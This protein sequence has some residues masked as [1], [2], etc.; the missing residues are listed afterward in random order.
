MDINNLKNSEKIQGDINNYILKEDIG[1]GSFGKLKLGIYKPTGEE[2][3]IKVMNKEL[4]KKKM[5]NV[6]F[7]ENEIVTRFHHINVINV[8]ELIED[9]KNFYIIMEYCKNGELFEYIIKKR[10]LSEIESSMFFYQLINGVSYIHQKGIAHR[11]LKPENLLLTKDN[12]LKIIDFGLSHEF[13]GNDLLKTKCGSPSYAAPEL[14]TGKNYDGFKIDIWCC[15][16][17]LFSMVTGQLPFYGKNKSE[18]FQSILKCEP[19]YPDY[20]SKICKDLI[21][22]ILVNDPKKR[23]TIEE[24]KKSDFY[25]QG[26]ELC[27]ANYNIDL[28]ELDKKSYCFK[29]EE[30]DKEKETITHISDDIESH[31]DYLNKINTENNDENREDMESQEISSN[32]K[33]KDFFNANINNNY[34]KEDIIYKN[35]NIINDTSNIKENQNNKK[36]KND[37]IIKEKNNN[38]KNIEKERKKCQILLGTIKE[39]KTI[40]K[41]LN[42]NSKNINNS[43]NSFRKKI[44]KINKN[45]NNIT[46]IKNIINDDNYIHLNKL[47]TES[48]N[49]K[50]SVLNNRFKL[51]TNSNK[52]NNISRYNIYFNKDDKDFRLLETNVND[53][54]KPINNNNQNFNSLNPNQNIKLN[55]KIIIDNT[56]LN[57]PKNIYIKKEK[58]NNLTT[59]NTLNNFNFKNI[60][61]KSFQRNIQNSTIKNVGNILINNNLYSNDNNLNTII[62]N[63]NNSN[64]H[65]NN[66]NKINDTDIIEETDKIK[67]N[68]NNINNNIEN[69]G[70]Y[71]KFKNNIINNKKKFSKKED[72]QRDYTYKQ[73]SNLDKIITNYEFENN[74]LK[75][76]IDLNNINNRH[77]FLR[78]KIFKNYNNNNNVKFTNNENNY[79]KNNHRSKTINTNKINKAIKISN[80]NNNSFEKNIQIKDDKF[81]NYVKKNYKKNKNKIENSRNNNNI[82]RIMNKYLLDEEKDIIN[83]ENKF[84]I[85]TREYINSIHTSHNTTTNRM[86]TTENNNKNFLPYL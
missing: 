53:F 69:Y 50:N 39:Y 74:S 52:N 29:E 35:N 36:D 25:L 12:V 80:K 72:N 17:I 78:R 49:N 15:G 82:R 8:F 73:K 58:I 48:N 3:A 21:E 61:N 40:D 22:S 81:F 54:I 77:G 45:I 56:I 62:L 14:I 18:L 65:F 26:K 11:D 68:N 5:K 38:K 6:I 20:L 13:D 19:E 79:T 9:E 32:N 86:N 30:D 83:K 24:I 7:R 16:I 84:K 37:N 57:N 51:N 64:E 46:S 71:F 28:E 70:S 34:N 41:Y 33:N 59:L 67:I 1:Y 63:K 55:K 43:S 27:K 4:I 75:N 76:S 60:R 47:N 31:K 44:I 66:K 2:F 23:I 42:I 10:K 85:R